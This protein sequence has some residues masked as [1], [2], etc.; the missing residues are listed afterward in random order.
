MNNLIEPTLEYLKSMRNS[1]LPLTDFEA[2]KIN[3]DRYRVTVYVDDDNSHEFLIESDHTRFMKHFREAVAFTGFGSRG[4]GNLIYADACEKAKENSVANSRV[5]IILS[6][7]CFQR[8]KD[9][10]KQWTNYGFQFRIQSSIPDFGYAIQLP[11]EENP[12]LI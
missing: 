12:K 6:D 2:I 11:S 5:L 4:L 3:T 8:I 9:H 7:Q 1:G 10:L